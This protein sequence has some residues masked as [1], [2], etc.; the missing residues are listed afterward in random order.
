MIQSSGLRSTD[1]GE[2]MYRFLMKNLNPEYN[3]NLR[4]LPFA[5]TT[6]FKSNC[7]RAH[8]WIQERKNN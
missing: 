1:E 7:T 8:I 3:P 4:Q 2:I 5:H 6:N